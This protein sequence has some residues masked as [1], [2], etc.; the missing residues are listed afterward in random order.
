ML[1]KDNSVKKTGVVT[2]EASVTTKNISKVV[3]LK[4]VQ[5][6]F[7][8]LSVMLIPRMMGPEIYGDYA[9]LTSIVVIAASIVDFMGYTNIFGRFVPEFEI[10]GESGN[11]RKLFSNILSLKIVVDLIASVVLFAIL[12]FTYGDRFPSP[13]F[14][15]VVGVLLVGDLGSVPWTLL[16]GLNQLGKF[17]LRDPIR[18]VLSLAF[19]LIL[20]HYYGLSGAIMAYLL[21]EFSLALLYFF[22]TRKYFQVEDFRLD[23]FFLRPY[24]RF[25][26]LFYVSHG[27]SDLWPRLGNPL[28]LYI[29]QDSR[30]VALFDIPNQIFLFAVGIT[31]VAIGYLVPVFTEFLSTGKEGK[32]MEWSTLIIKY[33]SVLCMITFWAFILTGRDLIPVVIGSKYNEIF[34]NGVVL[35]LGIFPMII[36]ELGVVFSVIYK[37]PRKYFLAL[38][39]ALLAFL[40]ASMWLIPKYSSLG[41]AIAT[42]ISCVVLALVMCIAFKGK[43]YPCLVDGFKVIIISFVFVPFLFI[44]GTPI[45]NFLL[46][47]CLIL[48]YALMLFAGKVLSLRE[49][50]NIVFAVRHQ[51]EESVRV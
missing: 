35:L 17:A 38:C 9:L 7:V 29:T 34:L 44:R 12:H 26:F 27:L 18:K 32:L 14:L 31:L 28:I 42:L 13:Y 48:A 40:I 3:L 19:T 6:P 49:I 39:F 21:V 36:Y 4:V 20:F 11:I 41:C 33:T 37:E 5:Y 2:K 10:R 30:E 51:S 47:G 43:L 23:L 50:K 15:L 8:A 16:F 46:L 24:L 22:W 25:G 1:D 45:N